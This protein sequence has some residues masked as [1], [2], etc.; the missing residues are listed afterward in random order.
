MNAMAIDQVP[1]VYGWSE[2]SSSSGSSTSSMDSQEAEFE[3]LHCLYDL[4]K[5]QEAQLEA[6]KSDRAELEE[7]RSEL[8]LRQEE[9][10]SSGGVVGCWRAWVGARC[11]QSLALRVGPPH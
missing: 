8:L 2:S 6:T 5:K 11:P 9:G 7:L 10:G 1:E 4:L 3:A